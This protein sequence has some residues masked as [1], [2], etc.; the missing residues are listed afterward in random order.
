[1]PDLIT[2]GCLAY[3]LKVATGGPHRTTFL[4]GTFLPD[5][6]GRVPGLGLIALGGLGV[7][8]P[9]WMSALWEPFHL[10]CGMLPLALLLTGLVRAPARRAVFSNLL[11]GMALHLGVDLL[12]DHMGNGYLLL[13]PFSTM[14]WEL[15]WMG[16][17]DSV[18]LAPFLLLVT[19]LVGWRFPRAAPE[20][21]R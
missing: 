12:Q 8:V 10:P 19:L 15:G 11:G 7:P 5:L 18:V 20:D 6:L 21:P 13:F 1:M 3:L 9:T 4:A 14:S 16:S 17:E 2:H